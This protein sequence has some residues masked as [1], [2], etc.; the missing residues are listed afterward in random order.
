MRGLPVLHAPERAQAAFRHLEGAFQ[1]QRH[2]RVAH[3]LRVVSHVVNA[4]AL[5]AV[6][7]QRF[8]AAVHAAVADERERVAAVVIAES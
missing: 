4:S 6:G 5:L 8:A 1:P 3:P 7:V 2:G